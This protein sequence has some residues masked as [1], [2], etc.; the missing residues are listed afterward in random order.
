[1]L[2]GSGAETRV[3]LLGEVTDLRAVADV[4]PRPHMGERADAYVAADS[5]ALDHAGPDDRPLADRRVDHL[6]ARLDRRI[7]ADSR[8]AAQDHV[9]LDGDVGLDRD[10]GVDDSGSGLL[11]R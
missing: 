4:A 5:G 3:L 7:T 9:R 8:A 6:A 11:E 1:M 10:R 2:L